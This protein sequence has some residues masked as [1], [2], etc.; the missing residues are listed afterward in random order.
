MYPSYPD[1]DRLGDLAM[2]FAVP[3]QAIARR[4]ADDSHQDNDLRIKA[5][6][7]LL[8]RKVRRL[9]RMLARHRIQTDDSPTGIASSE[10]GIT[11]F[12]PPPPCPPP[13]STTFARIT[14]FHSPR[15]DTI[16]EVVEELDTGQV[17]H[18]VSRGEWILLYEYIPS[19]EM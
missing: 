11:M 17:P 15:L 3:S 4:I 8:Y 10:M 18:G 1:Y 7:I 13:S 6:G 12:L 19:N 14:R 5:A 2:R 16:Q 9:A